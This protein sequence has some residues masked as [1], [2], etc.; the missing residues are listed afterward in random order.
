VLAALADGDVALLSRT[1]AV[2]R[3]DEY[4]AA[5]VRAIALGL[6]G[7]LVQVGNVVHIGSGD[8]TLPAGALMLDYRQRAIVYRKGTQ[9]RMRHIGTGADRLLRT[10]PVKPWQPMP[11]STDSWGSAWATGATVSW[12]SGPLR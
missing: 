4:A 10:I 9:V 5:S 11:F 8:V 2:L 3:T 6:V 7:A 12:R 1:G